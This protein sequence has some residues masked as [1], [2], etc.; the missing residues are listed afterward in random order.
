M[1]YLVTGDVRTGKTRWLERE[2]AAARGRGASVFGVLAPGVWRQ[3][4]RGGFEK[5]GIDNVLLPQGERLRL[6][7]RRDIAVAS[8]TVEQGGQSERA[9]LGWSM[10]ESALARVDAHFELLGREVAPVPLERGVLVVDELGR[11]ELLHGAGLVHA[12]ELL[13]RG[14]QPAW[15]DAVAVVRRDLLPAARAALDGAWDGVREVVPGA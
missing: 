3:D 1:L 5:L 4:G 11:L 6:A 15:S 10:S 14:P 12:L 8:G 7:D 9:G 2:L 13:S